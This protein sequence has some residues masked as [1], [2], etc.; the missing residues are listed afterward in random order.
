[1]VSNISLTSDRSRAIFQVSSDRNPGKFYLLDVSAQRFRLLGGFR[2]WLT[3]ND[4]Q[5]MKPVTIT[6]RDGLEMGAYLTLPPDEDKNLPA[7]IH[8]HGG[9]HGVRHYWRFDPEVQFLASRGFAVLQVNYRGSGG[10]GTAFEEAGY[11]EWGRKMQDDLTD[12]TRWLIE[13]G[14]AD[15]DRICIYGASYGGY[16][17][18]MGVV[19]EPELYRCA[20]SYVGVSDLTLQTRRSD[21]AQS[22]YG[23]G[24]LELVLGNDRDE[25]LERSPLYQIDKLRVPVFIAHGKDDARVPFRNATALQEALDQAGKPYEWLAKDSEGHGFRQEANRFEFYL[26]LGEFLTRHTAPKHVVR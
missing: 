16:A 22:R 23:R 12:A 20:V 9:P 21:T 5:A 1:M 10:Y 15:A 18:L 2:D 7:V 4:M 8:V 19:R 24:Y 13:Q 6:A 17:S 3:A 11:R 25:L 14:I 26:R